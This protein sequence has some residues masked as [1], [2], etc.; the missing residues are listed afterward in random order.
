MGLAGGVG[1]VM[2]TP[3]AWF[4]HEQV[5]VSCDAAGVSVKGYVPRSFV[6]LDF[7]GL[8]DA[9]LTGPGSQLDSSME[10]R[11]KHGAR[12]IRAGLG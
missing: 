10:G 12:A 1:D 4:V 11:L 3:R 9:S 8:D 7:R 2:S 5:R 6:K